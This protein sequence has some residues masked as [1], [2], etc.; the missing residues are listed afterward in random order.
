MAVCLFFA[1]IIAA[2]SAADEV[3]AD[4]LLQ[5]DRKSAAIATPVISF[6]MLLWVKFFLKL[7]NKVLIYNNL[8]VKFLHFF[9]NRYGACFYTQQKGF[10]YTYFYAFILQH[11]F[12]GIIGFNGLKKV[13]GHRRAAYV[14]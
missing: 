7:N 6:F 3:V 13:A 8:M 10:A 12:Y 4:L 1:V 14:I 2:L 11:G 9:K 5:A